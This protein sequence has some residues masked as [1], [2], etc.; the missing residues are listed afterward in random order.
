MKLAVG[1]EQGLGGVLVEMRERAV[2]LGHV[3]AENG[4]A[5][6]ANELL[7]ERSLLLM[8]DLVSTYDKKEI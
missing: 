6:C 4:Q 2:S 7:L 8:R 3:E 1:Q 5:N